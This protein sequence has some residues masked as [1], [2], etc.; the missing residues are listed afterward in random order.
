[1][2]RYLRQVSSIQTEL[3]DPKILCVGDVF[4]KWNSPPELI[5]FAIKHLP[6]MTGIP[7]NHDLPLHNY[8]DIKKSAY[9]TLVEAGV[10][11]NIPIH[12]SIQIKDVEI[13][14]FP[15]GTGEPGDNLIGPGTGRT[16]ALVHDY[17]WTQGHTFPYAPT[18][19]FVS[20]HHRR[21]KDFNVAVFGDNHKGFIWY[22]AA[23]NG[24]SIMNVGGFIRRNTDERDYVPC[25]GALSHD[26]QLYRIRL[27]TSKDR[28]DETL[29]KI[30]GTDANVEGFLE[31]LKDL[32]TETLDFGEA[33]RR[34][35][36]RNK[37]GKEVKTIILK[38]LEGK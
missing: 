15:N 31:V 36:S 10:I 16:I 37:V 28:W 6:K 23:D 24:P 9:W 21:L 30:K 25:I 11:K 3:N 34:H 14:G 13:R 22:G 5:N 32:E 29:S 7:G 38:A 18:D 12:S 8:T 26:G 33:V 19:K 4:H 35:L 27:D 17:C 1:M 2:R 20:E